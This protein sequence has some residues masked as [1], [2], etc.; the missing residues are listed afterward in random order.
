MSSSLVK[1][2]FLDLLLKS[3]FKNLDRIIKI[4]FTGKNMTEKKVIRGILLSIREFAWRLYNILGIISPKTTI[5]GVRII[6]T[7]KG[8]Y[9]FAYSYIMAVARIVAEV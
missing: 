1:K 5:I 9:D 4:I 7:I 3:K 6:A 8:V 2:T